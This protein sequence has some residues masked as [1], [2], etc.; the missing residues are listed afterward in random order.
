MSS[1]KIFLVAFMIE[2]VVFSS[3]YLLAFYFN[4]NI[5][6]VLNA[7]ALI[8]SNVTSLIYLPYGVGVLVAWLYCFKSIFVLIAV[9]GLVQALPSDSGSFWS[10]S[11][12]NP[13]I[14]MLVLPFVFLTASRMGLRVRSSVTG[15]NW[16]HIMGCG[17]IGAFLCAAITS[18][19]NGS[20]MTNFA[21]LSV[22]AVI[23]QIVFF[24]LLL[25]VY[26]ARR[27]FP[28]TSLTVLKEDAV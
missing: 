8:E 9:S 2:S 6:L 16:R 7:S 10:I 3:V 26:K 19:I 14:S 15:F 27:W 25:G 5:D 17:I 1:R 13:A 12:H 23:G 21:V 4:L 28:R 22:S 20:S 11:G 24:L 18:L